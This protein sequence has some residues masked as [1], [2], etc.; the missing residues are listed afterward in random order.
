[1]KISYNRLSQL[2]N[3]PFTPQEIEGILTN[4]GLEVEHIE[5][6]YSIP[7]GLDGIVI[8]HVLEAE[9]HP[10]ADKLKVCK[11][12]VGSEIKQIVC[13]APNV[14]AGQKVLV[15][16][17]GSTVHPTQGEP[18]TIQK[19]KIRGEVSEGMICAEDELSL[20]NSHDGILV[21]PNDYETGKPATHYFKVFK[22]TLI[23][24][25]LTANRGDA[26]SHLGVARDLKAATGCNIVL[27]N[28]SLE[29]SPDL[30][31]SF[32]ITISDTEGCL[33]Y[34]GIHLTNIKVQESPDWL[35]QFLFT[36]GLTPINNIVDVT[37]YI[38]H[39][40]GQPLHAFDAAS[41]ANKQIIVKKAEPNTVFTTLDKVE[42]KLTGLEC[43]IFDAEKPLAMAGIFGGLNSGIAH[44]TT[45]IFIESAYFNPATI[46]KAAKQHGL[47][48]DASFRYERG[49]DP[50]ITIFALKAA[51]N[52]ILEL[53]GGKIASTIIDVYPNPIPH[54][55]ISFSMAKHHALMGHVMPTE[56]ILNILNRLDIE[57]VSNN[58]N[59]LELLVP[60]YRPDVDRAVDV[61]EELLRIYGL[62]N[63]PM[64]IGFK[65][66]TTFSN[67]EHG[68]KLK[69][70]I[71]NFLAANGFN[72]IA[73]N[74]LTKHA[75]ANNLPDNEHAAVKILNPLSSDLEIMR[76]NM[77]YSVLDSLAYNNNRKQQHL[78]FFEFG[79]TYA[80]KGETALLNNY[81]EQKHLAIALLGNKAP[82][83][84]NTPAVAN[85][86]Y[87]LKQIIELVLQVCGIKQFKYLFEPTPGYEIT[88]QLLVKNKPLAVLGLIDK[89][90]RK[91]FDLDKPVWYADINFDAL[92][93]LSSSYQFKLKPV[94]V[95]P[96]V[97]RD[98]ALVINKDVNYQKL[99]D[100]ASKTEPKLLKDVNVFDVYMGDK[101]A[102]DKKSYAL[103]FILQDEEKTLTEE[104]IDSVMQKLLTQFEKETGATLRA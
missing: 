38:L 63:I 37:N 83:G 61:S 94:S 102:A 70:K 45:D 8:G 54:K 35:K 64:G 26:A 89:A 73:T 62:N 34:S 92:I 5:T 88:A 23:E 76:T 41:I 104:V 36:I 32:N 43:M 69:N 74:T 65:S 53:A 21:L 42:R 6:V 7:G 78:N 29:I 55:K 30:T 86:F 44:T 13:G 25:G 17:V 2:V 27:P 100:I 48:T 28:S 15:A 85:D 98:L 71:A 82:E 12:D 52:L 77:L 22:D 50:N 14:A 80:V 39:S 75:Y 99:A 72:E 24:I 40:Y 47:S 11:V 87:R 66:A 96:S 33:R 46:R 19:A 51:V 79:K 81:V 31:E 101:I 103:S 1:M 97:R 58:G 57:V 84:W 90:T 20:G 16:K 49:T 9:K 10:N 68:L 18:F 67:F 93:E 91:P 4:T 59:D 56:T 95:F 60:P 3:Q